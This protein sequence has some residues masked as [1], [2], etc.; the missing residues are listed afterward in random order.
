MI[1]LVDWAQAKAESNWRRK[2]F[3]L[4]IF[5]AQEQQLILQSSDP[6]R[7]VWILWSMKESVYKLSLTHNQKRRYAPST[8]ECQIISSSSETVW[9]RVTTGE[10][11]YLTQSLI[12]SEY[13][14]TNA[15]VTDEWAKSIL[16]SFENTSYPC[17]HQTMLQRIQSYLTQ[18]FECTEPW[19]INK[20]PQGIT[21]FS[22]SHQQLLVPCTHHGH[23]GAFVVVDA[24][25]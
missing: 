22:S 14:V 23:F 24:Q 15:S 2:G 1:D 18:H 20:T 12:T 8:L 25:R 16:V 6:D 21:S 11:T 5:S 13:V 17:Q 3:L 7:M 9:G 10:M 19:L 4:K